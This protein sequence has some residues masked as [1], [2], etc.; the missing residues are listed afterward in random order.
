[1]TNTNTNT[2]F[3][4]IFA[5]CDALDAQVY[6]S[7]SR[8]GVQW[9]AELTVSQDEVNVEAKGRGESA[10]EALAAAWAKLDRALENGLNLPRLAAPIAADYT[11]R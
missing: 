7:R 10:G 5:Q 2:D 8:Y 9:S 4:R 11:V 3:A 6:M 1:M